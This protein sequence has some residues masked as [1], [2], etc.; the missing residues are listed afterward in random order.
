MLEENVDEIVNMCVINPYEPKG[1]YKLIDKKL[2]YLMDRLNLDKQYKVGL[3]DLDYKFEDI[4]NNVEVIYDKF[5]TLTEEMDVLNKEKSKIE[6]LQVLKV[7][8]EVEINL[9]ELDDMVFF[10]YKIGY[11]KK[12]ID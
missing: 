12:K 4:I 3:E 8:D 10:N 9:K 2:D 5:K 1:I 6:K 7:I 11:L